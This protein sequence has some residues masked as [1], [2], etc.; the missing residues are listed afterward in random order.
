MGS[1]FR[2]P[3]SKSK[4]MAFR[5]CPRRIWLEV[6]RPD[7]K[8]VDDRAQAA[9]ASGN[10]V[11]DVA[12]QAFDPDR[13]GHLVRLEDG[14]VAAALQRTV[15]LVALGQPI[16]EAGFSANGALAFA[17]ILLPRNGWAG[18]AWSMIE[19]KASTA[20]KDYHRDDCAIQA[21]VGKAA[22]LRLESIGLAHLD[23]AWVYPGDGEYR[24][25][26]T[27]VD[28][29]RETAERYDE[30]EG[31]VAKAHEVVAADREPDILPGPQCSRP[32]DCPFRQ[33]C[34]K[35]I[36]TPDTPATWL[37]DL[38]SKEVRSFLNQNPNVDI[39]DVPGG[40]LNDLQ[41]RVQ[42][43]TMSGV[44]YFD[45]QAAA[46][47]LARLGLPALFLDF[48]TVSFAVPR[49]RGTR[50]YEAIPFQFSVHRLEPDGGPDGVPD[51]AVSHAEFI[52][53]SGEDPRRRLAEALL[54]ACAGTMSIFVYNIAFESARVRE[55]A[56]LFPDLSDA[57]EGL[58][59]R[60]IDLLPIV[61]RHFYHPSQQGSWSI[62]RV[63]PAMV[64]EMGYDDLDGV[65]SGD[66]VQP[67]FERATDP[68]TPRSEVD[69]LRSSMLRYCAMDT[70]AMVKIWGVLAGQS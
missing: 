62:K 59:R 53:L 27:V 40:L 58:R 18:T 70:M 35:G 67:A 56:A 64:P 68:A 44:P 49:W 63:L 50:A 61:R 3:L 16:F 57:L 45:H 9:F 28:L 47:E 66:M 48:E 7:L 24:G 26:F 22:G 34:T 60:L 5:Q 14:G 41:R 39:G 69:R 43:A 54:R 46:G 23:N 19:V 52:D 10:L 51:G 8:I 65:A 31:W 30:V 1:K 29:T 2:R 36:A 11:G 25:L 15:A 17:D 4:L 21:Y 42:Q 55:L 33:Q 13:S 38:R 12:R 20:I 32:F 6:H 37:P